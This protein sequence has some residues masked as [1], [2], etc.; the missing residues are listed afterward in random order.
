MGQLVRHSPARARCGR[1]FPP[2][3]GAAAWGR[4]GAPR[5]RR[6]ILHHSRKRPACDAPRE[7]DRRGTSRPQCHEICRRRH[8]GSLPPRRGTSARGAPRWSPLQPPGERDPPTPGQ[9]FLERRLHPRKSDAGRGSQ[10]RTRCGLEPPRLGRGPLEADDQARPQSSQPSLGGYSQANLGKELP[11]SPAASPAHRPPFHCWGWRRLTSL[12]RTVTAYAKDTGSSGRFSFVNG[13]RTAETPAIDLLSVPGDRGGSLPLGNLGRRRRLQ[14]HGRDPDSRAIRGE[15]REDV[16]F[17][18]GSFCQP[19][20]EAAANRTTPGSMPCATQRITTT[21]PRHARCTAYVLGRVRPGTCARRPP[22]PAPRR[23]IRNSPD[24]TGTEFSPGR[25]VLIFGG[26]RTAGPSTRMGSRPSA[27][28]RSRTS[29]SPPFA[30]RQRR[31]RTRSSRPS[32][33]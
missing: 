25:R 6:A 10:L 33:T 4:H 21:L 31:S 29:T 16:D 15:S 2:G 14:D 28:P 11:T 8:G 3:S 12:V 9:G 5:G 24:A 17:A 27:V 13:A 30:T 23:A 7:P 1:N 20:R 22:G 32:T 18:L 19:N 26:P